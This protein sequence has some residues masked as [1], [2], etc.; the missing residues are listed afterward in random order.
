MP[1]C[2]CC[3]VSILAGQLLHFEP[4][5]KLRHEQKHPVWDVPYTSAAWLL[6]LAWFVHMSWQVG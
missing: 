3:D 2:D 4:D 5:Q 6:Q 1:H